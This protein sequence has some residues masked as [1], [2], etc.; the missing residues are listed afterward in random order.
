ML[1]VV[2]NGKE[3]KLDDM[4]IWKAWQCAAMELLSRQEKLSIEIGLQEDC[5]RR[6]AQRVL[7]AVSKNN[8]K[9]SGERATVYETFFPML[10]PHGARHYLGICQLLVLRQ[11]QRNRT[12]VS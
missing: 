11:P 5:S 6:H 7:R 10:Q 8:L 2:V 1:V 3:Y 4:F 12:S 9:S